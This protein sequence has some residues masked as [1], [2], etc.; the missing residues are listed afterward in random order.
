MPSHIRSSVGPELIAKAVRDWIAAVGSQTAYI[1][2]DSVGEKSYFESF[3][4]KLPEELL[5]GEVFH[6]LEEASI[7]IEQ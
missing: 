7:V 2:P 3:N 6:T 4:A 5:N 1:E